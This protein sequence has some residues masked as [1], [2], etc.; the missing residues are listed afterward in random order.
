MRTTFSL[1]RFLAITISLIAVLVLLAVYHTSSGSGVVP[2]APADLVAS[3]PLETQVALSWTASS[4]ATSYNIYRGARSGGETLLQ[5]G[6]P[7][8][9]FEDSGLGDGQTYYY[10]VAAVN[11]SGESG[12][13]GEVSVVTK[14]P[15]PTDFGASAGDAQVVLKWSVSA[16]ATGYRVY[17]DTLGGVG[18]AANF[19]TTGT[20]FTD[21][22][23]VNGTTYYY[24]LAP[25]NVSGENSLT[26][27]T[28]AATP[29]ASPPRQTTAPTSQARP[30]GGTSVTTRIPPAPIHLTAQAASGQIV[31]TWS[32]DETSYAIYR[33]LAPGSETVLDSGLNG[34]TFTDAGL[35]NGVSYFYKVRALSAAGGSPLSD[36]VTATPAGPVAEPWSGTIRFGLPG[37]PVQSCVAY[38]PD[39]NRPVNGALFSDFTWSSTALLNLQALA[40]K[41]NLI[42]FPPMPFNFGTPD[43][44]VHLTTTDDK[45]HPVA[46]VDYRWPHPSGE[47]IQA[48]LSA[49][50]E[51]FPATHPEIRNTGVV[52]YGFSEGVDNTNTAVSPSF[53]A[54]TGAVMPTPLAD[55]VLAVVQLSEIDEDRY[56]PLFVMDSVPHLFLA[57]GLP[58]LYSTLNMGMQDFTSLSHD[59]FSRGLSTNQGAPLTVIDNA[60]AGHGENPDHPFISI[61]LDSVLSQR[62]PAALPV[63]APMNLPSW[64]NNA[65]WVGSY[66]VTSTRTAP[67]GTDR[68]AGVQLIHA[69]ISPK[70]SYTDPRPFTWLPSQNTARVWLDYALTGQMPV[71]HPASSNSTPGR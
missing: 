67:W 2:V 22:G 30:S 71:Y 66:D 10:E 55:R 25:I 65:A 38:I 46:V 43:Q 23:L 63:S 11:G 16:T 41:Y 35:N 9:T 70:Y 39:L 69:V 20:S 48:I 17:R 52:L 6:V 40:R 7:G 61:W 60:G 59:V 27:P 18:G 19:F 28:L 62:L 53:D 13:S 34:H 44:P 45:A 64:Q 15:A 21:T 37:E 68:S 36:E 42:L 29:Q 1:M 58:D 5:R 50:A 51:M 3:A 14:A 33:G 8:T 54:R 47:R 56:N 57:S 32:A 24:Q 49:A 26:G 31:L 12:R 4:G